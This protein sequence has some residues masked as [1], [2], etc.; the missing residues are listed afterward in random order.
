MECISRRWF[1]YLQSSI[2]HR[3]IWM[4]WC[5]SQKK[6]ISRVHELKESGQKTAVAGDG[7]FDSP[8]FKKKITRWIYFYFSVLFSG[9]SAHYCT[10]SLQSLTTKKI[11]ATWVAAKHVVGD[12]V[13]LPWTIVLGALY[14]VQNLFLPTYVINSPGCNVNLYTVLACPEFFWGGKPR[15]HLLPNKTKYNLICSHLLVQEACFLLSPALYPL[16]LQIC[17]LSVTAAWATRSPWSISYI[18][19][20]IRNPLWV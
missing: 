12:F 3:V 15:A 11:I 5:F 17:S 9:F 4:V 18:K 19:L 6:E 20:V 14:L 10:Y 8:G 1:F 16:R 7:R 2:L 13:Y